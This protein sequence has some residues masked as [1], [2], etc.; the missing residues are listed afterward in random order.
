[1]CG[2]RGHGGV[3]MTSCHGEDFLTYKEGED[4]ESRWTPTQVF[5]HY[6]SLLFLPDPQ[7]LLG[8]VDACFV[9]EELNK[10]VVSVAGGAG[11]WYG[12]FRGWRRIP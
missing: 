2:D 6:L 3:K 7:E 8:Q 5:K 10:V 12:H 4:T 11:P 1:M 9:G